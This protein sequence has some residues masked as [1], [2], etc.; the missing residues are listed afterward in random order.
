MKAGSLERTMIRLSL[1]ARRM[2]PA[3]CALL[4]LLTSCVDVADSTGPSHLFMGCFDVLT[5]V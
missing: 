5:A 3:R 4:L 1:V 2:I